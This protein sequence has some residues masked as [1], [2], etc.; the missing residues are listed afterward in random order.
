MNVQNNLAELNLD[1]SKLRES[2]EVCQES[3]KKEIMKIH[4]EGA[5]CLTIIAKVHL[6]KGEL[7]N[8]FE[9]IDMACRILRD[10][11]VKL[12]TTSYN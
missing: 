8:A 5:K 1:N 10:C 2:Y 11:L 7:K 6:A 9:Q 12:E 4:S 3:A